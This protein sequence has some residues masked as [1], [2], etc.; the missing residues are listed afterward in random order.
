MPVYYYQAINTQAKKIKGFIEAGDSLEAK[1][2]LRAQGLL[3]TQLSSNIKLKKSQHLNREQLLNFTTMLSQLIG[4][5]LPLYES[6]VAIEEQVRG[7]NYHRIILNLTE[8][9][10]AGSSLSEA[11]RNFPQSFNRLYVAMIGAG[12]VA[13]ALTTVLERLTDFLTKQAKLAKQIINALIYPGILTLFAFI[14]ILLLIGFVVPSIEGIFEGRELN[15]Y[16]TFVLN[17]SRLLRAYWA[18]YLP[19][20]IGGSCL[21]F[22]YLK[23][24]KGQ[25]LWEKFLMRLPFIRDVMIQAALVRFT[26]TMSTLQEGGVPLVDALRLS[27]EVMQNN[28]LEEEVLRAEKRILEGGDLS[29]EFKRSRLIPLMVTRMIAVGEESGQ[30]NQMLKKIAEIYEGNLEKT[31]ERAMSLI[32]PAILIIMGGI[33]GMVLLAI[34]LPMSDISSLTKV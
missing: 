3:I 16:T 2:K 7:E 28:A 26:R 25:V 20:L 32:Q 31:I 6:L 21:L 9:V 22:Y 24:P 29:T 18:A 34:L 5:G 33:I 13:G 1:Q 27:R 4:A 23:S 15:T 11:M 14:V 12:E 17:F 30:L 8:Q 19:L 10:K